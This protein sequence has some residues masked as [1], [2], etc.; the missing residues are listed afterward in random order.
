VP[1]PAVTSL[2]AVNQ[3]TGVLSLV[4]GL[5]GDRWGYRAMMLAGLALLLR[6]LRGWRG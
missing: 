2:I 3:V 6:G 1:L 5:L 4:F